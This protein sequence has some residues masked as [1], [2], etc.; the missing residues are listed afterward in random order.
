M[1]IAVA[2]GSSLPDSESSRAGSRRAAGRRAR[3]SSNCWRGA[4]RALGAADRADRRRQDAGGVSAE[5]GGAECEPRTRSAPSPLEGEGWG[6]G[7]KFA[8]HGP[9][10]QPLPARG[11]GTLRCRTDDHATHLHRPRHPPRGRA[12]HALHLA[13]EGARGRHRAQSRTPGRRN[14]PA[15]PHR[16]AHR[17]HA[18]L[19]APAP[20]PR[21]AATSCSPRPS[22]SRCCSPRPMRP[23]CSARSSA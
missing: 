2:A 23:I 7:S 14:G 11:R 6:G 17:R 21:S 16:D 18:G 1:N 12:A 10:P 15:D 3:I 22:S 9:P 5:P 13:A 20:A 8:R 19:E 4:G